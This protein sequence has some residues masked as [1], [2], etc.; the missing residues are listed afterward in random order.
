MALS[1]EDEM[2]DMECIQAAGGHYLE[3]PLASNWFSKM[4]PDR[5]SSL[6]QTSVRMGLGSIGLP[7]VSRSPCE[8]TLSNLQNS[9]TRLCRS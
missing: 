8:S 3:H 5:S 2:S 1:E 9:H 6:G 4:L 7:A